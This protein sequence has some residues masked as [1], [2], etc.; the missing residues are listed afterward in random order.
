MTAKELAQMLNGREYGDEITGEE[1]RLAKESGL[2]VVFGY[3]DD[4]TEFRG[5][6]YEEVG[7]Y[8][9][10]VLHITKEGVQYNR[11]CGNEECPY[12]KAYVERE[13]TIEA[14]WDD[15]EVG[16]AWFYKTDI[17]HETFNIYEDGEL[18][19]VGIVFSVED[20]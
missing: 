10:G 14:V 19:C 7:T 2:V 13:R 4:N 11:K 18:F 15:K 9:G 8:D 17:P 20:L 12:Y 16:A 3:S 6:F 1:S 5:V